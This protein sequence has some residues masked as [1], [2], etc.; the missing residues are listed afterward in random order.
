MGSSQCIH[1]SCDQACNLSV[2]MYN[3]R[4]QL[5]SYARCEQN[6]SMVWIK[7]SVS[8]LIK[9]FHQTWKHYLMRKKKFSRIWGAGPRGRP[10]SMIYERAGALTGQSQIWFSWACG[11]GQ[12]LISGPMMSSS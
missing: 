7:P 1:R 11:D 10:H 8:S 4:L 12:R 5:A 6:T 3:L 9:G 2:G